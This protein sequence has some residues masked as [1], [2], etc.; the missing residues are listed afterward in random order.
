VDA[1]GYDARILA[2]L[3]L[4]RWSP[5]AI[6][7]E[8]INLPPDELLG[9]YATLRAQDYRIHTDGRDLVAWKPILSSTES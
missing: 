1:E 4:R 9:V 7:I 8:T 5:H 3:D 2:Q 6:S